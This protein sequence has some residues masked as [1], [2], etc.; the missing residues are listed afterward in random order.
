MFESTVAHL[1]KFTWN[2]LNLGEAAHHLLGY[3]GLP[4]TADELL[5]RGGRLPGDK[6]MAFYDPKNGVPFTDRRRPPVLPHSCA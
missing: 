1:I 2:A 5:S 4:R 6:R 3:E